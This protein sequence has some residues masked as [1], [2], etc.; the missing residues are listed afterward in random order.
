MVD[1]NVI[2]AEARRAL[3]EHS[4]HRTYICDVALTVSMR[5]GYT[6]SDVS[7]VLD[8]LINE[9]KFTKEEYH[10]KMGLIN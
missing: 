2:E 4:E 7:K 10:V 9:G 3:E 8:V 6:T 5:T 1:K